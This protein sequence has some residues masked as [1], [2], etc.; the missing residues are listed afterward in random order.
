MQT[1]KRQ[2]SWSHKLQ[3]CIYSSTCELDVASG[4]SAVSHLVQGLRLQLHLPWLSSWSLC[5]QKFKHSYDEREG[6]EVGLRR[7]QTF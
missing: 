4:F 2:P 3:K 1:V 7:G 6:K 5:A